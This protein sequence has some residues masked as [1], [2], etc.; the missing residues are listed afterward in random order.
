MSQS[1]NPQPSQGSSGP[2]I[3][4]SLATNASPAN[5]TSVNAGSSHGDP[6]IRE[7]ILREVKKDQD[8][9]N[10][11]AFDRGG[12]LPGQGTSE[13]MDLAYPSSK[14]EERPWT[15]FYDDT[16]IMKFTPVG[17]NVYKLEWSR[18]SGF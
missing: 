4:H 18:K 6:I 3:P 15:K 7:C 10:V 11:R 16:V 9:I 2:Y 5:P 12:P 8:I 17:S 1:S 14:S 13:S